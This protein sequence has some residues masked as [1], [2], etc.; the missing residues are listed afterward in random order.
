M[1]LLFRNKFFR[2]MTL[3]RVLS[4][5]GSSIY[6]LV[7]VVFAASMY[8]SSIAVNIANITMAL[9]AL[10]TVFVGMAADKTREKARRVIVF[11]FAQAVI[12]TLVAIVVR[13]SGWFA[14][15]VVCLFNVISDVMGDYGTGLRMPMIQRNV[16]K[17]DL[18]EAFSFSS[19]MG[20]LCSLAGQA[21]G[22]WILKISANNYSIVALFNALSFLLA[23]LVLFFIRDM[24]TYGPSVEGESGRGSKEGSKRDGTLEKD[25]AEA[26]FREDG[27][28]QVEGRPQEGQRPQSEKNGFISHMKTLFGNLQKI[29]DQNGEGGFIGLLTTALFINALGGSVEGIYNIYLLHHSIFS[30][31]YSQSLLL[32]SVI[33]VVGQLAGGLTPHDFFAK[34]SFGTLITLISGVFLTM[35]LLNTLNAPV[36]I[37]LVVYAFG[38]FLSGKV[39]PKMSS[40]IMTSLPADVLAETSNLLTLLFTLSI[41]I[42]TALFG[43]IAAWNVKAGW[44]VFLVLSVV[45]LMVALLNRKGI[46]GK[47]R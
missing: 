23:S 9:P 42:G 26:D 40:M 35:G 1:R 44:I 12:F 17:D 32:V 33:L 30:L 19:V 29:F 20:T 31:T 41:P 36:L 28:P 38:V 25:T 13:Q 10:F 34:Q 7:F 3:S 37:S 47:K 16:A 45:T 39:N 21:L 2:F 18:M 22:V 46:D 14:F 8:H 15:S 27:E 24:L 5:L 11:G 4:A 43:T 6:N